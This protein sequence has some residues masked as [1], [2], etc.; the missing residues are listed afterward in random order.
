M[1]DTLISVVV[2]VFNAERFLN[3]C[4][5]SIVNQTYKYLEIILVNDGSTD[6]SLKICNQFA[7]KDKRV[8][9]INQQN[10]GVVLARKQ[11][12][13][14]AHGKYI[15]FIDS[16][17]YI[18]Q[19]YMKTMLNN[20]GDADLATSSLIMDNRVWEDSLDEGVYD[21]FKTIEVVRNLIYKEGFSC[22]GF[23]TS[24]SNKL[25][26]T[27]IVKRV[28][29][30]VDEQVYY[31]EDAEFVYKYILACKIVSITKYKGY[32]YRQNDSSIT[33]AVHDDFL[34]SVNRM[35]LS[36]KKDFEKSQYRD[37][38]MPQ[39][40]KWIAMHIKIAPEKMGFGFSNINYVIS[41]K[42]KIC[43]KK[44]V[45]YGAGNVGKDYIR[46]IQKENL[47]EDY[48]WVDRG[49]KL[50]SN[51]M[52]VEVHSPAEMMEYQFDYV[53]IAVN[54]EKVMNE[55]KNEL[56]ELG[57]GNKK[58]IWTKPLTVEEFYS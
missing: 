21:V 26:K 41:C 49:Y 6:D 9:V 4:V 58:I 46:Q 34:I 55:I 57:I 31:G 12:V 44:I 32:F 14:N 13:K 40:K 17:D 38:L 10:K 35:Y 50:K 45:V 2:P 19:E 7:Q 27:D 23:V 8:T 48:I 11:G 3:E 47:C 43:N 25:F 42:A 22:N 29:D 52:G 39:L 18:A 51:Y 16:D 33:H 28:I 30:E 37:I 54:N 36:L 56:V 20:I 15:A 5:E 1:I 24:M 53:I